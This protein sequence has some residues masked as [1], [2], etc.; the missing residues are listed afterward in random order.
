MDAPP[1]LQIRKPRHDDRPIWDVLFGIFGYPAVLVAHK[2]KLFPLLAE[3]PLTI[4]ELCDALKIERRP[5]EA[6]LAVC[7]SLG[8][9]QL[10]EGRYATTPLADDYL[11]ES[12]PA[13]FCGYLDLVANNFPVWSVDSLTKAVLTNAPQAYGGGDIFKTHEERAQF[14]RAFTLAM[15]GHSMG[16]AFFWPDK[17]D[18]SRHRVMLD[19]G[20]GSG[21]HSIGAALRWPNLQAIVF[22]LAPVCEVAE[23]FIRQY[24]LAGRIKT[25]VGDMWEEGLFPSADAHFYS[26][27]YHDWPPEKCRFLTRKSFDSLPSGG[28]IILHEMLFHDDKTGPFPVAAFNITMLLWV[29][30]Q[31]YSR[32]ELAEMLAEAGFGDI[33]VTPTFG[34]WSIV[35]GVKP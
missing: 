22:D 35:T 17:V 13:S 4:S 29:T 21:C 30:G 9:I 16:P 31:Q 7:A 5:A 18:L 20:G 11:L 23:E 6:L 14:A 24:G 28:R 10:V 19:I 3:K 34:Y 26:V 33:Q 32:R 25:A 1:A 15:H 2:L 27:I 12:S 8:F